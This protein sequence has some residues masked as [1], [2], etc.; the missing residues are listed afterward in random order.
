[1]VEREYT[2]DFTVEGCNELCFTDQAAKSHIVESGMGQVTF[3]DFASQN[4]RKHCHALLCFFQEF[5]ARDALMK[6]LASSE[7]CF[8][9]KSL[10]FGV[11]S[12]EYLF[13]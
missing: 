11:S 6:P 9:Q 5:S 10:V 8:P 12:V 13:G 2:Y 1:M 3:N 4:F 7:R